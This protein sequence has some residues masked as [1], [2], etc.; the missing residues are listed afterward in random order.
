MKELF[1]QIELI[2]WWNLV[3]SAYELEP[4]HLFA[5]PNDG[6]CSARI[7]SRLNASGRR[8]GVPDLMLCVPA[9]RYHGLFI[10]LKQTRAG[11][12][13]PAQKAFIERL[14]AQGYAAYVAHGAE[15]AKG[16]I[17]EYLSERA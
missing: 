9:G 6:C 17:K 4:E 15:A 3:C 10:E 12:A 16:I 8:A 7:G 2:D 11:R 13:S 5:I 14:R 1:E